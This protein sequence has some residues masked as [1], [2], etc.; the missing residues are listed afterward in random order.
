MWDGAPGRGGRES[1][2]LQVGRVQ[3]PLY[4]SE[5]QP[6]KRVFEDLGARIED[7]V[8]GTLDAKKGAVALELQALAESP[9][10]VKRLTGWD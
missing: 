4:S 10:E 1:E 8:F 9:E 7:I 6:V 2:D 5:L 3:P